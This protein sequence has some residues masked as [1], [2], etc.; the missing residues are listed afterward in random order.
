MSLNKRMFQIIIIML[1]F[2]YNSIEVFSIELQPININYRGV[3][4]KDD[5]IAIYGDYGS[6]IISYDNAKSWKQIRVFETGAIAKLYFEENRI[7]TFNYLGQISISTDFGKNWEEMSDLQDTVFSVLKLDDGYLILLADKL[8]LLSENFQIKRETVLRSERFGTEVNDYFLRY[9]NAMTTFK[10]NFILSTYGYKLIVFNHDLIPLDTID[11]NER[12]L[13]DAPL[14]DT[15]ISMTE[16]FSDNDNIYITSAYSIYKSNDLNKFDT[17]YTSESSNFEI[18][19]VDGTMYIWSG[20]MALAFDL[21][22]FTPD[23]L[24]TIAKYKG[25]EIRYNAKIYQLAHTFDK[26]RVIVVGKDKLIIFHDIKKDT[27]ELVSYF[28]SHSRSIL[29]DA[30]NDSTFLFYNGSKS[31]YKNYGKFLP[32]LYKTDDMGLTFKYSINIK[33]NPDIWG[34]YYTENFNYK[35]FD[36]DKKLLYLGGWDKYHHDTGGFI[37]TSDLGDKFDYIPAPNLRFDA[38]EVPNLQRKGNSF[39]TSNSFYHPKITKYF[40]NVFTFDNNFVMVDSFLIYNYIVRHQH[41]YD[42]NSFLFL[43]ENKLDSINEINY[44]TDKGKNFEVIKGYSKHDNLLYYHDYVTKGT[45]YL[46]MC[47]YNLQDSV[48]RFEALNIDDRTVHL[49]YSSKASADEVD[50]LSAN[51][52]FSCD[53]D[54]F[55]LAVRDTLFHIDDIYASKHNKFNILPNNGRINRTLKK[56]GN[57]FYVYYQ[58]DKNPINLYWM[59]LKDSIDTSVDYEVENKNYLYSY[60]PYPLPAMNEVRSLIYWDTS[61]EIDIEQ[62]AVYNIFGAK[63]AGHDKIRLDKLTAYSGNL[64]WDCSGVESG[65]YVIHLKHGTESRII[66]VIVTK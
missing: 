44:T 64:V 34:Y 11:L 55:Y 56:F 31:T 36:D 20:Y 16:I 46:Y 63:V 45:N 43:S 42:V 7:T 32:V 23:S 37:V 4:M 24:Q 35:Y 19:L 17:I 52:A 57:T 48:I 21:Y 51:T 18:N 38:E 40:S 22:K 27:T 25:I 54:T 29:P 58:D 49:I 2:F 33:N 65:I 47:F 62:I 41:S 28:I 12:G 60:P 30:I 15:C 10:D 3:E 8:V 53:R 50:D 9:M 39:I 61:I 26:D 5:T 6:M 66:K 59:R 1:M 13:C 14:A